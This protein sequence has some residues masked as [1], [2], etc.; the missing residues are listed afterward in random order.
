MSVANPVRQP[1][2]DPQVLP[3][4]TTARFALLVAT[5]LASAAYLYA[6][7]IEQ[8][9]VVSGAPTR[10][11][12]IARSVT[13]TVLPRPLITWY[14]DCLRWASLREAGL[15][16]LVLLGFVG[17]TFVSYLTTP[18]RLRRGLAPLSRLATD[19]PGRKLVDLV[20]HTA[21]RMGRPNVQFHV[22]TAE[23]PA[24]PSAAW[25]ATK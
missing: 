1:R 3:P 11:A 22:D 21:A 8:L 10:C 7:L 9:D 20:H 15:V 25:A 13:G 24:T 19:A 18:R 12:E 6:W 5:A 4:A 16:A 2:L 17:L 14:T 23:A